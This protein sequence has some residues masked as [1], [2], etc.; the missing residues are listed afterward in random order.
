[1]TA[2]TDTQIHH[3]LLAA[4]EQIE[5]HPETFDFMNYGGPACGAPLCVLGWLGTFLHVPDDEAIYTW[6]VSRSVLGMDDAH[7]Y[8]RMNALREATQ[9]RGWTSHADVCALLL[10]LYA[11]KYH[12]LPLPH[13]DLPAEVRAIFDAEFVS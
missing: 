12:P 6:K 13:I 1:M 7:F 8:L 3:A 11:A 4:A 9:S 5:G 2:Y 10:R